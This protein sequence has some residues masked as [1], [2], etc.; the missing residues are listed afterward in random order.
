MAENLQSLDAFAWPV[1]TLIF[2]LVFLVLFRGSISGLISR[3]RS[4]SKTGVNTDLPPEA[5]NEEKNQ[6]SVEQLMDL[7]HSITR[8]ELEHSIRA[9]LDQR[10]VVSAA[11]KE[12][13]LIRYLAA[14]QMAL[15][16]QQIY[17]DI[18]GSQITLLRNLNHMPGMGLPEH[19]GNV[20]IRERKR[21]IQRHFEGLELGDV[22]D[23]SPQ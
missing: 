12:R 17:M 20:P 6:S 8:D 19:V 2:G 10:G 5:Q 7:G 23:I 3:V 4:R 15:S 14:T 21:T 9:D 16:F 1:A 18:F 11:D 13:V 22:F